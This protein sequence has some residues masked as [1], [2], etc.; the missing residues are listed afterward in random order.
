MI[1]MGSR[2]IGGAFN[3]AHLVETVH[4]ICRSLISFYSGWVRLVYSNCVLIALALP[5]KFIDSCLL[6]ADCC[7]CSH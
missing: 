1:L 3:A 4:H 7:R 6:I 2:N 5:Y